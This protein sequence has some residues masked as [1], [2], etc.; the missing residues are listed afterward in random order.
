MVVLLAILVSLFVMIFLLIY[1]P[2]MDWIG[3]GFDVLGPIYVS[4]LLIFLMMCSVVFH[5][6]FIK[7]QQSSLFAFFLSYMLFTLIGCITALLISIILLTSGIGCV[8]GDCT[9]F[10]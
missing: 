1:T 5:A 6:F 9:W 7:K 4:I 3:K 10:S 2:L 8:T